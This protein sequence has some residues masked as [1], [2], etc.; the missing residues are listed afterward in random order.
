MLRN[1]E[2]KRFRIDL[3]GGLGRDQDEARQ[4]SVLGE[5]MAVHVQMNHQ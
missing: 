2:A 3:Q 1:H 4:A 5:R